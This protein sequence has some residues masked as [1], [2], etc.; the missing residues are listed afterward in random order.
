MDLE[1]IVEAKMIGNNSLIKDECNVAGLLADPGVLSGGGWD[2]EERGGSVPAYSF[3]AV[4]P[5]GVRP[6]KC[7]A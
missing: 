5:K 1:A 6:L 2:S 7:G 4:I 3:P